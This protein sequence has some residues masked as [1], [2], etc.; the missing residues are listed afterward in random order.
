MTDKITLIKTIPFDELYQI[1][2]EIEFR[3]LYNTEGQKIKPYKK[4]KFSTAII[5]PST[6]IGNSPTIKIDSKKEILFS[7]QP[8]IYANQTDIIR[9]VDSFLAREKMR[10]FL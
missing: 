1:L 6:T 4:A 2:K 7:P 10:V 9:T 8:T 3:G 5:Y